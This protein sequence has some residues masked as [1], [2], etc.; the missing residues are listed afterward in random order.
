MI[1]TLHPSD[2]PNPVLAEVIRGP[3]VELTH[4]GTAVV[5]RADGEIVAA[6][7]DPGRIALPRSSAKMM[8][9]LPLVESGAADAAGLTTRHLALACAS[10]QGSPMHTE[11]AAAWLAA[12]GFGEPDLRCGAHPPRDSETRHNLRLAG[13]PISQLHNNCSGKHTGFLTLS[14]HLGGGPEYVEPDH[15]VQR[16][17][18]QTLGEISGDTIEGFGIDGCSAPNFALSI[19]GVATALARFATAETAFEGARAVA[20][21]R[22]RD[23]MMAHPELVD[24]APGITTQLMRAAPGRLVAKS[25]AD[26]YFVAILPEQG[27][28]I[29]LKTDDGA[30]RGRDAAITGL[31]GR[32]G[33][34]DRE[35]P[36]YRRYADAPLMNVRGMDCGRVRAAETLLT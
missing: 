31:L 23:A 18:C 17:V 27:L 2:I 25:G 1:E 7:G 3:L 30:E 9:A 20:A 6:W 4:R 13:H 26:G 14:R 10:H 12:Q 34:L 28:G 11:L 16:A 32:F 33:V 5:C 29:A 22:L 8:Q 19:R 35:D 36:V 21:V 24:G 15:P